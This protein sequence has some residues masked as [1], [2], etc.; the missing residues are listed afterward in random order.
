LFHHGQKWRTG[1]AGRIAVAKRR[2]G[3]RRCR[4]KGYVGMHRWVA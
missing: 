2:R 3:L 4:Y 1:S